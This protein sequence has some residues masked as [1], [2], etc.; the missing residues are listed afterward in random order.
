MIRED[1]SEDLEVAKEEEEDDEEE[2]SG[3][4]TTSPSLTIITASSKGVD[5][6]WYTKHG[7]VCPRRAMR[8][9]SCVRMLGER[10]WSRR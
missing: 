5:T 6:K 4:G 8:A 1:A 9:V 7:L 10:G 2:E 3:R